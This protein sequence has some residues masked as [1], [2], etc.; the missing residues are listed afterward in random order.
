[1]QRWQPRFD[2]LWDGENEPKFCEYNADTPTVLIES[3]VA[4]QQWLKEKKPSAVRCR[5]TAENQLC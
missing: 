4:Q 1:M 2:M 5:P 3:G